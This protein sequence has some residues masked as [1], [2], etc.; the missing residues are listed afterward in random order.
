MYSKAIRLEAENSDIQRSVLLHVAGGDILDLMKNLEEDPTVQNEFLRA[1]EALSLYFHPRKNKHYERHL[2]RNLRQDSDEL[3]DS[4]VARLRSQAVSC[5]FQD[6]DDRILEQLIEHCSSSALRKELLKMGDSLTLKD[7]LSA[8]RC[9]ESVNAQSAAMHQKVSGNSV[10]VVEAAVQPETSGDVVSRKSLRRCK[11]CV[12]QH[13][14]L[15]ELCPAY[16]KICRSDHGKL[17]QTEQKSSSSRRSGHPPRRN[18]SIRS[19]A[20]LSVGVTHADSDHDFVSVVSAPDKG[21]RKMSLYSA[22]DVS[23][24]QVRFLLDT[25]ASCNL[26]PIS[27]VPK[28]VQL[29][30]PDPVYMYD[31]SLLSSKGSVVLPVVNPRTKKRY[32]VLFIVI[33]TGTPILGLN[34]VL[35]ME[36][37]IVSSKEVCRLFSLSDKCAWDDHLKRHELVFRNE[38]GCIRSTQARVH[39]QEGTQPIF[40]RARTVP[41]AMREKV[42]QA[43]ARAVQQGTLE[44]IDYSE[45]ASPTVN[46]TKPNGDIRICADFSV[47]L[48]RHLKIDEYPF[49]T[50]E[51]LLA[52]LSGTRFYTKLD[53]RTCF[54]QLEVEESSR[55]MLAINTH[56]GLYRYK[57]LP[58]G[59][60]SAPAICQRT[61]EELLRDLIPSSGAEK[62]IQRLLIFIDDLLLPSDTMNGLLELTERVLSKIESIGARLNRAKCEFGARN[63]KYLGHIISEKGLEPDPEK[64]KCVLTA[65]PPRS[66]SELRSFLGLTNYYGKFCPD[67]ATVCAPL[68]QLLRADADFSWTSSCDVAFARIKQLLSQAPVLA[69][70]DPNKKLLLQCDASPTGLGAVLSLVDGGDERPLAYA[71]RALSSAEKNYAQVD[72]E[73]LSI[74]FGVQ[75]FHKYLYGRHFTVETDH[76]PLLR[77]LGGKTGLSPIAAARLSRY[78]VFLS[79]YRYDI[80]YKSGSTHLNADALSRLPCTPAKDEPDPASVFFL[81]QLDSLPVD[82]ATI[83]TATADDTMLSQV[84]EILK[85]GW[86]ETC[87][88]PVLLEFFKRKADLTLDNGVIFWG[89]RAVI[90]CS[91]Q[92]QVLGELHSGHPGI[93]RMKQLACSYCWWPG[94]EQEIESRV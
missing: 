67:L 66:K 7:A 23:G 42:E 35:K 87:L 17:M 71:H 77:I 73:A 61:M 48:N 37:M 89:R 16:G 40:C 49:P 9:F 14:F 41:Y 26:L 18:K 29:S 93:V 60:A 65:D 57:R 70:F 21:N 90:P 56:K 11:F 25:G 63:V 50:C 32:R 94:I 64:V 3:V 27:L 62:G 69:H 78:A 74:V 59:L 30:P 5:S 72:G 86:P 83:R 58:Y 8:A 79:Q 12:K 55:S 22:M 44:K 52:Q 1:R 33:E 19:L 2:F 24:K 53:F 20:P 39:L 4:F 6:V 88:Q 38:L 92:A 81:S 47:T 15:K 91:L 75:K 68:N 51:D 46:V 85:N 28:D 36:L 34:A 80:R 43:L 84:C 10:S 54:E 31:G 76:R 13:R 82:A 45:W